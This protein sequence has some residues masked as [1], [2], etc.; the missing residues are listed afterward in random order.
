M[1]RVLVTAVKQDLS[2]KTQNGY[3]VVL[4]NGE[5]DGAALDVIS[6]LHEEV[7]LLQAELVKTRQ[8]L[9]QREI[10]LRDSAK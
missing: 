9:A 4:N 7:Q 1:K 3:G 8:G 6:K 5:R 2:G 10:L